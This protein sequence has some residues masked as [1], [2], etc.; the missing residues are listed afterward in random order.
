MGGGE[1]GSCED[2]AWARA[3][4]KNVTSPTQ[5]KGCE[6]RRKADK[7]LFGAVAR[8]RLLELTDISLQL[9]AF[10]PKDLNAGLAK[11]RGY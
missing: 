4:K 2:W 5:S 6:S 9:L 11:K 8:G 1:S 10:S 7:C 3:M